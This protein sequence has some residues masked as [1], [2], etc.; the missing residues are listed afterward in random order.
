MDVPVSEVWSDA[1]NL[2]RHIL[3]SWNS[4]TVTQALRA[5]AWNKRGWTYQEAVLSPRRLTF[6]TQFAVYEGPR[7]HQR[8]MLRRGFLCPQY[9]NDTGS[10]GEITKH[11][12]KYMRRELSFATDI[13]N[14]F[15]GIE[16]NM[17]MDS[18]NQGLSFRYGL[19]T[20]LGFFE[21]DGLLWMIEDEF[22]NNKRMQN[23]YV[24]RRSAAPSWTW[25]GWKIHPDFYAVRG[26]NWPGM[27]EGDDTSDQQKKAA[28]G[29]LG[30]SRVELAFLN[31]S[32]LP[33]T[34]DNLGRTITR[35]SAEIPSLLIS[36]WVFDACALVGEQHG[37]ESGS[38]RAGPM[39][40]MIFPDALDL[41]PFIDDWLQA[42]GAGGLKSAKPVAASSA[43]FWG[44]AK[45][46]PTNLWR[47]TQM[48]F[49]PTPRFLLF[50]SCFC[51][52]RD[53]RVIT[54]A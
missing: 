11:A 21:G 28:R 38:T 7:N 39:A 50:G 3:L 52:G 43:C 42:L 45:T 46:S 22:R 18:N 23:T 53:R 29:N 32:T 20:S 8:F 19:P 48:L 31:G 51:T 17:S 12:N 27:L 2:G 47:S 24:K 54:S 30:T 49:L 44:A 34:H 37:L 13:Y 6:T 36:G 4:V 26:P 25:L 35:E 41:K 10:L 40:E 16:R 9:N 5:S 33:W 15:R 14:A 1:M